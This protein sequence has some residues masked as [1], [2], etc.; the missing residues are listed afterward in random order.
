MIDWPIEVIENKYSKWYNS[1]VDKA[2]TR[3]LPDEIY[4]EKHHI[5][6]KSWGGPNTKQ[7]LVKLTAREHYIAHALLW[8]FNIPTRYHIQMMHAFD[9]M[10]KMR[11]GRRDYKINSRIFESLKLE[12]RNHMRTKVGEKNHN[13]GK[14]MLPHVKDKLKAAN[15]KKYQDRQSKM[16]VGPIRPDGVFTFRGVVYK[17]ICEASRSTGISQRTMKTQIQHWGTHPDIETIKK[18]DSGELTYPKLPAHNKGVAMSEEQKL[19]C[20][21]KQKERLD[22]LRSQG[23]ALPNTGRTASEETRK[24]I[25]EKAIGRTASEET[26]LKLSLAKKGKAKSPEHVENIRL[27]KLRK[28]QMSNT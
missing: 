14:P 24:K 20:S 28:K 8:K 7:N 5:I 2:R 23:L 9:S 25:S 18:I 12:H 6:P 3:K 22:N 4:I 13:F 1:L 21:I 15:L 27:A 11:Y 26:K 17:G 16:F 10:T 19:L